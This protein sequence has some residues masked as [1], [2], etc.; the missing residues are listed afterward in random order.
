MGGCEKRGKDLHAPWGDRRYEIGDIRCGIPFGDEFENCAFRRCPV[1]GKLVFDGVYRRAGARPRRWVP[2]LNG[3]HSTKIS[4]IDTFRR[5]RAPALRY[6]RLFSVQP[7]DRKLAAGRRGHD[8][9][10]RNTPSNSNLS[11]RWGKPICTFKI[12]P[13]GDTTS[14]ISYLIS[15]ISYLLSCAPYFPYSHLHFPSPPGI[16]YA[17]GRDFL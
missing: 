14:D 9:A 13:E 15:H 8:P 5:G 6:E 7:T 11:N 1:F 3:C 12:I 4:K 17:K 10:L 16:S 2:V